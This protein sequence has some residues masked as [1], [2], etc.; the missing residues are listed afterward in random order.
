[1]SESEQSPAH[2]CACADTDLSTATHPV[3]SPNGQWV[4]ISCGWGHRRSVPRAVWEAEERRR[5]EGRA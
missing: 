4:Q 2:V 5:R 3:I 1:M